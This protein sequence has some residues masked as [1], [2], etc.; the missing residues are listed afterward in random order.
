ML[1]RMACGRPHGMRPCLGATQW[2]I[3]DAPVLGCHSKAKVPVTQ[4]LRKRLEAMQHP[5]PQ[6]RQANSHS[7]NQLVDSLLQL[8]R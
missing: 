6:Q 3:Q 2:P 1:F 4:G 8:A 5:V 7:T